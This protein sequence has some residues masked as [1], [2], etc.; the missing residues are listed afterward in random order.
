M[1]HSFIS[2]LDKNNTKKT[3][4]NWGVIGDKLWANKNVLKQIEEG[5]FCTG[6][7]SKE[8]TNGIW[9]WRILIEKSTNQL[10]VGIVSDIS[11]PHSSFVNRQQ[12]NIAY[13]S[14]GILFPN[15]SGSE[16]EFVSVYANSNLRFGSNDEIGII[17]NMNVKTVY[18]TKNG[19]F[20]PKS[21]YSFPSNVNSFYLAARLEDLENQ[22]Q[23]IESTEST[24]DCVFEKHQKSN[25]P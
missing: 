15:F 12:N 5:A 14:D 22:I 23:I 4:E 10:A 8:V 6:Y 19:Y 18:F 11:Y 21:K 20:V 3:T 7:G 2:K 25:I 1:L 9:K 16:S 17:L 13:R 24:D